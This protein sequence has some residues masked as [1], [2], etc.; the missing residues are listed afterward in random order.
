MPEWSWRDVRAMPWNARDQQR[1]RLAEQPANAHLVAV[2]LD[3]AH[4]AEL[5]YRCESQAGNSFPG[6][7]PHWAA[8]GGNEANSRSSSSGID[9]RVAMVPGVI[10]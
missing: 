8:S 6:R 3:V 4:V 1:V 10:G 7:G 5:A 2:E 9:A